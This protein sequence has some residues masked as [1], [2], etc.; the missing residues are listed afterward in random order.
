MTK[1]TIW[2]FVISLLI[3]FY[4]TFVLQALWNWFVTGPLRVPEISYWAMFG[5]QLL[6]KELFGNPAG[7]QAEREHRSLVLRVLDLCVPEDRK[8][9]ARAAIKEQDQSIW[10]TVGI[11]LAQTTMALMIG[12]AIHSFLM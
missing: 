10:I 1:K 3:G 11:G 12:G 6:M 8:E 9:E 2:R 4:E 5:I 7:Q